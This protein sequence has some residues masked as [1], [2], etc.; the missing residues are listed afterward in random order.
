[1]KMFENLDQKIEEAQHDFDEFYREV[2]MELSS[3]YGK[4]EEL[5]VCD[6]IGE[7]MVGNVYVKVSIYFSNFRHSAN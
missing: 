1:M 6:N 2:Y 5:N 4:V 7:H 3:E